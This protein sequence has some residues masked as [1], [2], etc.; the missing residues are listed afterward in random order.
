MIN[1]DNKYKDLLTEFKDLTTPT[2]YD[3]ESA[4]KTSVRH[5]IVTTGQPVFSRAR[6]LNQEK[7][8][9]AK[10]EFEYMVS[11][12]ICTPSK[13]EWAS[14][15]NMV[16]KKNG[17]W[18]PC[19]DYRRVNA[20]TV[21][22]RYPIQH[23]QDF[24]QPLNGK[25]IFS[26]LDLE[27]AY[28]NIPIAD[29][30]RKKTAIITPFGLFEF[31]VMTFGLCNAAQTFQRF[32]DQVFF[33]LDFVICYIDDICI[34][35][36]T[37]EEHYQH[38]RIVLQR[39]REYALKIN[40]SKCVFAQKEVLFLGHLVNSGGIR[41]PNHKI[42]V[43]RDFPKPETANELR[44]FIAMLNFYRRFLPNAATMQGRLQILVKGNKK[45]DKTPVIWTD[46]AEKAFNECKHWKT[47]LHWHIQFLMPNWYYMWMPAIS[48]L[49]QPFI[50]SKTD[51]SS[52]SVFIL[53][54]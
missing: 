27:K 5:H 15:L 22:D 42:D 10:E 16:P 29:E 25:S 37:E 12:G 4:Q 39:L 8:K 7:L 26:T 52:L 21:P 3:R 51:N 23:I 54:A 41:P 45:N 40:V 38:I 36:N 2:S 1:S 14:P 31:N 35:S 46:D 19:G 47:Q 49:V 48:Q 43:I 24:A 11:K 6:R 30:D 34:A 32:M 50:T 18:R 13:S 44:R 9:I 20:Q 33:G 28:F 53:S 17:L